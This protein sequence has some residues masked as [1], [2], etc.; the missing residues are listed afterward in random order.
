[1]L[2]GAELARP[3]DRDDRSRARRRDADDR[4]AVRRR[5][6]RR[7]AAST[8]RGRRPRRRD[9][10]RGAHPGGPHG[11][12]IEVRPVVRALSGARARL[13]RRVGPRPRAPGRL[14]RRLRPRRGCRAG[15]VRDRRRAL[16]PR[17]RAGQPGRLAHD[18]GAQ[19]R[20][21]PASAASAPSPRRR[22]C[23]QVP[24]AVEDE[25]ERDDRSRR[26]ARA[27][28]H[29]LPPGARARRAGRADAAHARRPDDRR[30]RARVPRPRADDGAAARAREA[31]DPHRRHPVPRPAAD[32]LL[33]DR[34]AAVLAVVYLVF[35]E[36]YGGRGDLAAEAI[37]LGERARRADARRA[38][39]ARA[40]SR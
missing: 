7:S 19:P 22:A 23:S 12:A 24:E 4:R 1:M 15:G 34:L 6:R 11:G 32:H 26:A 10:D 39:G 27:D 30:D 2:G 38:R 5:R 33:P 35:N 21:R 9:R 29:V 25:M 17:R 8:C 28:L 31:Q 18:D 13:P 3:R 37:R 36:G 40:C 16:A 14:P 20:D